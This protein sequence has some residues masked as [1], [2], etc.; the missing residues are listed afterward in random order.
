MECLAPE[1]NNLEAKAHRKHSMDFSEEK[2]KFNE[3]LSNPV[4]KRSEMS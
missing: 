1:D 3:S 4:V 2:L